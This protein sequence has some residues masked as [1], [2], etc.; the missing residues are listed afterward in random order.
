MSATIKWMPSQKLHANC[1][2]ICGVFAYLYITLYETVHWVGRKL[3]IYWLPLWDEKSRIF[4]TFRP[5]W[6][7]CK[8]KFGLLD[9][10]LKWEQCHSLDIILKLLKA[11]ID[12]RV[13]KLQGGLQTC[14]HQGQDIMGIH[15]YSRT[16]RV[17][18]GT[19]SKFIG[20]LIHLKA[21][22]YSEEMKRKTY[23]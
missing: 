8:A 7:L 9:S 5:S 18:K 23:T 3:C 17:P 20:I 14:R 4:S 10:G 22:I 1:K 6:E 13:W 12:A 21:A 16:S 11:V 19:K 2:G 15:K